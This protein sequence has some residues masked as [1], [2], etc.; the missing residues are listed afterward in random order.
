M[1]IHFRTFWKVAL[2]EGIAQRVDA[3]GQISSTPA[4][5]PETRGLRGNKPRQ[6]TRKIE[7]N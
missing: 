1:K 6:Y 3:L 2:S 5:D 7:Q 4:K